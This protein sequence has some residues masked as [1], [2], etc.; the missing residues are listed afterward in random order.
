MKPDTSEKGLETLIMRHLT[1]SDCLAPVAIDYVADAL[2]L[3]GG[4]GWIAGYADSYDR[5]HALDPV[6]LFIFLHATQPEE[7]KKLGLGNYKDT[8]DIVRLQFFD[9]LSSEIGKRGVIDV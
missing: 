6:Q 4:N 9:R 1:G 7:F 2:A 3:P 5:T 8:K